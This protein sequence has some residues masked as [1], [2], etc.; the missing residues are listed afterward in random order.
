[1]FESTLRAPLTAEEVATY[2]GDGVVC[3]RGRFDAGWVEL[4]REGTQRCIEAPGP[5]AVIGDRTQPGFFF[6]D[7]DMGWRDAAFRRFLFESPAAQI[8]A[9]LMGSHT[10]N[11]FFDQVIVKEPGTVQRTPWHQDLPYWAL[12]AQSGVGMGPVL[13][14]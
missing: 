13:T 12:L 3:L 6:G 1:M 8:A 2:R 7:Q 14:S 4:L 5:H 10:I 11:F 9:E